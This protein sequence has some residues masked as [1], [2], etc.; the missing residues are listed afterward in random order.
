MITKDEYGQRVARLKAGIE[1]SNLDAYIVS[2]PENIYYFTGAS[3]KAQERPFFIIVR[4]VDAPVFLVPK[5]EESHMTKAQIGEVVTYWEYPSPLG[6][7]WIDKIGDVLAGIGKVGVEP[8]LSVENFHRLNALDGCSPV[9]ADLAANL[10]LEKSP[11][12]IA[13]IR[14]AARYADRGMALMMAAAYYGISVLEMFALSKK[15]QLDVI[16]T[17]EFDPLQTEFLTATWPAPF[18]AKPHGVPPI[19][20]KLKDGPLAAMCYLRVNGYAAECER[21]FFLAP[22][23]KKQREMFAAMQAARRRAFEMVKPGARCADVDAAAMGFLK[24]KGYGDFLLHRTGHG[25]GQGNHEGPW[26]AEGG[27]HVL[28]ENMVISVEPGIYIPDIGGV[29]H[30]DTVLVT[31][32]GY[33]C[34]TTYPDDLES[35]TILETRLIKKLKGKTVQRYLG[36]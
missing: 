17:G 12:E 4:P 5:L 29:R 2:E 14:E 7:R 1:A 31:Q 15:L 22:P 23:D 3:Y 36:I 20:G 30:S 32:D 10:R 34:L 9:V 33:E 28:A 25:I 35:L 11:A 16:K 19:K 26:V 13:M 24:E 27:D 8:D 21:T 6:R 18:S